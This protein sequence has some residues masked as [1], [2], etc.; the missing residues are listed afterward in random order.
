MNYFINLF[1][2]VNPLKEK[3]VLTRR[4][5]GRPRLNRGGRAGCSNRFSSDRMKSTYKTSTLKAGLPLNPY[6]DL[7]IV[8][9]DVS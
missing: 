6:T 8:P 5:R 1:K 2:G 4:A 7:Q 3:A 9:S